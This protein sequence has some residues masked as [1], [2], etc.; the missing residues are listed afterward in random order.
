M[1]TNTLIA[2]ISTSTNRYYL[3][4]LMV[5]L[6]R[7]DIKGA[8]L[9]LFKRMQLISVVVTLYIGAIFAFGIDILDLFG[10]GFADGYLA[11]CI[12][13]LG[14]SVNTL[15]SDSPY[16]LQFMGHSRIV[17]T[18][19]GI[20]TACMLISSMLLSQHYGATGVAIGY[21]TPVT[22]LFC[23]FKLLASRHISHYLK[24]N[25]PTRSDLA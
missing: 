22:I 1:Q 6:E 18:L 2:L 25:V 9:L 21:A 4:M 19:T 14:A 17:V 8:K 5:L 7:Y 10:E 3:P 15:F 20:A 16:Y 12:C 11:L 23:S 13:A 24:L